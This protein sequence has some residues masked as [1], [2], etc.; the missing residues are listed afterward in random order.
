MGIGKYC[1]ECNA[2]LEYDPEQEAVI[3]TCCDRFF[4]EPDEVDYEIELYKIEK[5]NEEFLKKWELDEYDEPPE[6]CVACGGPYPDCITSCK[7]FDD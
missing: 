1:P 5:A 7:L 2:E 4:A 6:G 3:C